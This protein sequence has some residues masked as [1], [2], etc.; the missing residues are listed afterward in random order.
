MIAMPSARYDELDRLILAAH[1]AG[2]KT[3]LVR[4]YAEA[5]DLLETAS[6]ADHA[7]FVRTQAYVY[8][9]ETGDRAA[10]TQLLT[11]LRAAGREA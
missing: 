6:T 8:A 10:A 11:A 9:L 3:D 2:A 7:A 1:A 4:L 5:G